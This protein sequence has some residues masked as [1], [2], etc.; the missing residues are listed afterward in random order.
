MQE[1]LRADRVP[2]YLALLTPFITIFDTLRKDPCTKSKALNRRWGVNGKMPS[3]H[4]PITG[5]HAVIRAFNKTMQMLYEE[6]SD[7]NFISFYLLSELMLAIRRN[8][9]NP[10]TEFDAIDMFSAHI[11]DFSTFQEG[12]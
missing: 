5:S 3:S 2:I 4:L 12:P 1:I 7:G 6:K 10:E 9:G 8:L 11:S